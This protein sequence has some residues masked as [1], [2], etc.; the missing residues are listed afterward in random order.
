MKLRRRDVADALR[1]VR[2]FAVTTVMFRLRGRSAASARTR[3][4]MAVP[5][6]PHDEVAHSEVWRIARAVWRIKR[7]WPGK[8]MCLQTSLVMHETLRAN[9]IPSTLRIGVNLAD[10]ELLQAHAWLEVGPK[11]VLDD[12]ELWENFLPFESHPQPQDEP[13]A[14]L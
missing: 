3:V 4:A 11:Y 1:I 10:R 6:Q 2:A 12:S 5:L 14:A 8:P 9:G 7:W 13:V